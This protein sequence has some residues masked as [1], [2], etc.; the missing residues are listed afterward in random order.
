MNTVSTEQQH[1]EDSNN[2]EG[3]IFLILLFYYFQDA[4]IVYFTPIYAQAA[5]PIVVMIKEF[6]GGLFKFQLDIL[7]FAGNICPFP[8]LNPVTKVWFK[9][10]FVPSVLTV[11]VTVYVLS[12]IMLLRRSS[13]RKWEKVAGKASMALILA[14]LFSY[15]RLATSTFSLI[16]CVPVADGSVLFI[17]GGVKCQETWQT[18]LMFYIFICVVPFGIYIAFVPGLLGRNEISIGVFFLG[19]LLPLPVMVAKLLQMLVCKKGEDDDGIQNKPPESSLVYSLLQGPYRENVVPIYLLKRVSLCWNGV[20]II[21]RLVLIITYTYTHNVLLRLLIMTLISF[22]ALLHHLMVKPCKENRANVAGTVSCAALLS[23][24][25]INLVR[26]AF[27]VGE[28]IPEGHLRSIMDALALIE[29]SLLFWIP[30]IGASFMIL[31][32][33]VKALSALISKNCKTSD[34]AR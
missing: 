14:I 6:L 21:R 10:L 23:I 18:G 4:A 26:A 7:V 8:G 25:I 1:Q 24:C 29:D 31:F 22:V 11:L 34:Q 2:D 32:L 12:K 20:L 28:V 13:K 5:D 30:L 17:D 3:G 16:Y 33:I 9:L 19:C 15:Q 27:E